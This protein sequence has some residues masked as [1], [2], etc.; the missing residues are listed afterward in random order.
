M[1]PG[2]CLGLT[3]SSPH[4]SS[5]NCLLL[6]SGH[7]ASS[8]LS[9]F[10]FIC[11]L[12]HLQECYTRRLTKAG[13]HRKECDGKKWRLE[14][15]RGQVGPGGPGI[16]LIIS[17]Q[18]SESEAPN[19]VQFAIPCS[20]PCTALIPFINGHKGG[21]GRLPKAAECWAVGTGKTLQGRVFQTE[22]LIQV[23]K[24]TLS[25]PSRWMGRRPAKEV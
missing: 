9:I 20:Q 8:L 19:T 12:D 6:P 4:V 21:Q 3:P 23:R 13:G 22:R 14:R 16:P 11:L 5:P 24:K 17:A 18:C 25:G 10:I 7:H 1:I 2:A 15:K